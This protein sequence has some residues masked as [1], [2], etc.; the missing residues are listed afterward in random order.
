MGYGGTILMELIKMECSK[1]EIFYFE[2]TTKR[3]V[4]K[5]TGKV[6]LME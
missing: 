1:S 2:E 4:F 6:I 5:S 3:K